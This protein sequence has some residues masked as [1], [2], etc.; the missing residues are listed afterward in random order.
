MGVFRGSRREN[1]QADVE[2]ILSVSYLEHVRGL[3]N[4]GCL[5]STGT[6]R[7][8]GAVSVT[9][10]YDGDWNRDYVRDEVGMLDFLDQCA[11][12]VKA[13][14]ASPAPSGR[15]SPKRGSRGAQRGA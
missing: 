10:T 15:G 6:T 9:V 7:D 4:L 14:I 8:G 2:A 5:V 12:D 13:A 11:D 3:V 1:G